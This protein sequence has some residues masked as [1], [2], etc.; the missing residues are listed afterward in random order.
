MKK[1]KVH[2]VYQLRVQT[3]ISVNMYM[4]YN[5]D[6]VYNLWFFFIFENFISTFTMHRRIQGPPLLPF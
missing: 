3:P 6:N 2:F 5:H 4:Y 1:I